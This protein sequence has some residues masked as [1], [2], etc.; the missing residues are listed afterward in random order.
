MKFDLNK[1]EFQY[2]FVVILKLTY[3][4]RFVKRFLFQKKYILMRYIRRLMPL[5]NNHTPMMLPC[6][7][8][9]KRMLRLMK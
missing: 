8:S 3:F 6:A 2:I 1:A 4:T 5:L 7:P 9:K